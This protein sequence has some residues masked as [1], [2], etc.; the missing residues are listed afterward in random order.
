MLLAIVAASAKTKTALAKASTVI[1]MSRAINGMGTREVWM[2]TAVSTFK[3]ITAAK[4]IE[5]AKINNDIERSVELTEAA[6][7][8]KTT[9]RVTAVSA[10]N[11]AARTLRPSTKNRKMITKTIDKI[12]PIISARTIFFIFFYLLIYFLK[13]I[14]LSEEKNFFPFLLALIFFSS[15]RAN[16]E[17]IFKLPLIL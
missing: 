10:K 11:V 2:T 3:T 7:A 6:P 9:I 4:R 12:T 13:N 15:L 16:R 17:E 1:D 14:I 8:A 5:P